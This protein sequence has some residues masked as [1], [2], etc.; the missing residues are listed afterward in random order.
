MSVDKS[1]AEISDLGW[2][3]GFLC[4]DN[5]RWMANLRYRY[6]VNGLALC[7][8]GTGQSASEALDNAILNIPLAQPEQ[9][10]KTSF[11]VEPAKTLR[12]MLNLRSVEIRRII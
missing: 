11:A 3:L 5:E 6:P 2:L 9:P 12:Q 4:Q 10:A 8:Y 1:L 7:A